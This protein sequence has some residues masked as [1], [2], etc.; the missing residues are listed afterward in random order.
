MERNAS[1]E[2]S[3]LRIGAAV[4]H[5]RCDGQMEWGAPLEMNVLPMCAAMG[6]V[7]Q[8]MPMEWLVPPEQTV[9]QIGAATTYVRRTPCVWATLSWPSF[10]HTEVDGIAFGLQV[11]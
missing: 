2:D 8:R 1:P 5:V 11:Q 6:P 7:R 10:R 3:V 4:E 9:F